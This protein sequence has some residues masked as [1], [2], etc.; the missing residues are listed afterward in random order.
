MYHFGGYSLYANRNK[1]A[2][3]V[4]KNS[5]DTFDPVTN[6]ITLHLTTKL[7]YVTVIP[8]KALT[9]NNCVHPGKSNK[10]NQ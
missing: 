2:M 3:V 8:M 7:D 10:T 5:N 9:V 6:L 1:L 4:S